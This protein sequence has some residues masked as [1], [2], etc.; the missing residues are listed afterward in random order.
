LLLFFLAALGVLSG[1]SFI[2][3]FIPF[4]GDTWAHI[5]RAQVVYTEFFTSLRVPIWSFFF[6]SGYPFLQFYSP[7][8]YYVTGL[9]TLVTGGDV[10]T[11]TKLV[12]FL[13]HIASGFAM[14]YFAKEV[15]RNRGAAFVAAIAYLLTY[16]H[17]YQ[18][19]FLARYP[20]ALFYVIFPCALLSLEL[21]IRAGRHRHAL[22]L[23]GI[24]AL[25][26]LIHIG[27]A[28]FALL[29]MV[30]WLGFRL[31]QP[32]ER[33]S[34]GSRLRLCIGGFAG[35]FLLSSALL[36]P[37]A[38]ELAQYRTSVT[39]SLPPVLPGSLLAWWETGQAPS[40]GRY[41]GLSLLGLAL[42]G[43]IEGIGSR[44][45]HFMP[46]VACTVLALILT[47]AKGRVGVPDYPPFISESLG[48][49]VLSFLVTFLPLL[50][51]GGYLWTERKLGRR[52]AV[53]I[54]SVFLV[55]DLLPMSIRNIYHPPEALGTRY[56][57]YQRLR[58]DSTDSRLLDLGSSLADPFDYFRLAR[59]PGTGFIF[60]GRPSPLGF[61]W[62]F[63]SG[64]ADYAYQWAGEVGRDLANPTTDSVATTT[65]SALHL[66]HVG[67]IIVPSPAR[68]G[69]TILALTRKGGVDWDMLGIG[70]PVLPAMACTVDDPSQ[71]LVA[72]VVK[73]WPGAGTT[74]SWVYLVP[75]DWKILL[76]SSIVDPQTLA[77]RAIWSKDGISDSVPGNPPELLA[78][79]S[80][81]EQQR[82]ELD[83]EVSKE[84]YVRLP[85]SYFPTLRLT[86][87]GRSARIF[88]GADRF[89]FTRVPSGRHRLVLV[90]TLSS[91]RRLA[92]G[93]NLAAVLGFIGFA[94]LPRRSRRTREG[95]R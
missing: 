1:S 14:Y 71:V 35:A 49:Q 66:L 16:W 17:L 57:Y 50:A 27:F 18:V 15:F 94:C 47:F 63:A 6:Y 22:L 37:F 53:L 80:S 69:D 93:L 33:K 81:L 40:A 9:A 78:A 25:L 84:C 86:I 74:A 23:A 68:R 29:F 73:P 38:L 34:A 70:S 46:L 67:C 21:L 26:F 52:S 48:P 65:L 5:A 64:S 41:I 82:V 43:V 90:P 61:F 24:V 59:Y 44:H 76:D 4:G 91:I 72:N 8:L 7:L 30:V 55:G 51:G 28:A 56:N 31:A 85:Y 2:Q 36:L 11:G 39:G 88:C 75:S 19:L 42:V 20:V 79:R 13:C 3:R 89:I 32:P 10:F 12:L 87:D 58:Q 62:Q 77:L 83:I 92:A 60:A 45:R 54:C 95:C